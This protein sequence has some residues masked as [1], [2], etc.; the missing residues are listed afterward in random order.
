MGVGLLNQYA[1][2]PK[3]PVDG[4]VLAMAADC[5]NLT[6]ASIP[7]AARALIKVDRFTFAVSEYSLKNF[8]QFTCLC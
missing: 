6:P 5:A 3:R 4:C 1:A 2:T 7:A 8:T